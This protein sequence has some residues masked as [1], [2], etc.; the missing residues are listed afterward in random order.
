[1]KF[2]RLLLLLAIVL[3]PA[4]AQSS[5][6]S[7][8]TAAYN[9]PSHSSSAKI[10]GSG[11]HI[12][13]SGYSNP[14]IFTGTSNAAASSSVSYRESG[15]ASASSA[16]LQVPNSIQQSTSPSASSL[17][18]TLSSNGIS[19]VPVSS[20][21]GLEHHGGSFA[22]ISDDS[23]H[24][25]TGVSSDSFAEKS[26]SAAVSSSADLSK[27]VTT[28]IVYSTVDGTLTDAT[29]SWRTITLSTEVCSHDSCTR[30]I[31]TITNYVSDIGSHSSSQISSTESTSSL[32]RSSIITGA[33][34]SP[35]KHN[36]STS[37]SSS[38]V[39]SEDSKNNTPTSLLPSSYVSSLEV[40]S[41]GIPGSKSE[42]S[43]I[44]GTTQNFRDT[45][46]SNSFS[47]TAFSSSA[48]LSALSEASSKISSTITGSS[49]S[50]DISLFN[51]TISAS[52]NSLLSTWSITLA[53]STS[54]ASVRGGSS[55]PS[56][57]TLFDHVN[58]STTAGPLSSSAS[59][60]GNTS[61]SSKT[62]VP[63]NS[64]LISIAPKS[65]LSSTSDYIQALSTSIT[66]NLGNT[67][68]SNGPRDIYSTI[69]ATS[70]SFAESWQTI[71]LSTEVCSHD[72][73]TKSF[74]TTTAKRNATSTIPSNSFETS[75]VSHSV[76][77][78]SQTSTSALTEYPSTISSLPSNDSST[79]SPSP[80]PTKNLSLSFETN[81]STSLSPSSI[82][83]NITRIVSHISTVTTTIDGTSTVYTTWCPLTLTS[84]ASSEP[85]ANPPAS[86]ENSISLTDEEYFS[87]TS[88]NVQSPA[89][90]SKHG[91]SSSSVSTTTGVLNSSSSMPVDATSATPI[92]S[93]VYS[94]ETTRL[95][96]RITTVTTTIN[97]T[98]TAYTTWCPL[99]ESDATSR[100]SL[101]QSI[102]T[103]GPSQTVNSVYAS[104]HAAD[105]SVIGNTPQQKSESTNTFS[106]IND[107]TTALTESWQITTL[108]TEVCSHT[109]CIR[110]IL[111]TTKN[112]GSAISA[113]SSSSAATISEASV[114][115]AGA[116]TSSSQKAIHQPSSSSTILNSLTPSIITSSRF[117]STSSI[118]TETSSTHSAGSS[119]KTTSKVTSQTEA[120]PHSL[121][122]TL[123]TA[124][125]DASEY[126]STSQQST[127]KT[128]S[129]ITG[130]AHKAGTVSSASQ[131]RLKLSSTISTVVTT[132]NGTSTVYTTW[133]P[134][135]SDSEAPSPSITGTSSSPIEISSH[136]GDIP[137]VS[138]V[139]YTTNSRPVSIP[140]SIVSTVVT[141]INGTSTVY[142][143]WCP[144]TSESATT[145]LSITSARSNS[146][147]IS[148]HTKGT[149]TIAS[150][151]GST[152]IS[153][154]VF[155][156]SSIVS[157]IVTTINGTS[158]V[159]TTWCPLTSETIASSF[160]K[161]GS[162]S[163][164]VSPGLST[165]SSHMGS[166]SKTLPS[167]SSTITS[168]NVPERTG[169]IST[170]VTLING[171]STSYTTWCPLA[172]T[173]KV[174]SPSLESE[175][176]TATISNSGNVE[177]FSSFTPQAEV[178]TSIVH[179]WETKTVSTE[180]CSNR[181][182]SKVLITTS[183]PITITELTTTYYTAGSS[184][185]ETI[186]PSSA[187]ENSKSGGTESSSSTSFSKA[188][189]QSTSSRIQSGS[190]SPPD[191]SSQPH[192]SFTT[193]TVVSTSTTPLKTHEKRTMST[194]ITT[195]SGITTS[196]TTWCPLSD[197]SSLH[198]VST[199][200]SSRTT[201]TVITTHTTYSPDKTVS[202]IPSKTTK[203]SVIAE[204]GQSVTL[205]EVGSTSP[206][207]VAGSSHTTSLTDTLSSISSS[208]TFTSIISSWKTV[209]ISTEVCVDNACSQ[210]ALVTTT[211]HAITLY[212][213]IV[214]AN[215]WG[216]SS[217]QYAKNS[218][219]YTSLATSPS[220]SLNVSS[221]TVGTTRTTANVSTIKSTVN[222]T[223]TTYTTWCPFSSINKTSAE[224]S[225]SLFTYSLTSTTTSVI[226][227]SCRAGNSNNSKTVPSTKTPAPSVKGSTG[228]SLT[229]SSSS[230]PIDASSTTAETAF[231]SEVTRTISSLGTTI[232]SV[233]SCS[234][235]NC[236]TSRS[237][238]T[239]AAL[240][241][242]PIEDYP[243][244]TKNASINKV[245]SPSDT[246]SAAGHDTSSTT[247][248]QVF[249]AGVNKVVQSKALAIFGILVFLI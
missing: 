66:E 171:T 224:V 72:V 77:S 70:F 12:S 51:S 212:S 126:I 17:E 192:N 117:F 43:N 248:L 202:S 28:P 84:F 121:V 37:L 19:N 238:T 120:N 88:L 220:A 226:C 87:G 86:T 145:S 69:N 241:T 71:T 26:L 146:I 191:T 65:Q 54:G 25:S 58:I 235:E 122:S 118:T 97:G 103:F 110:S 2:P 213:T 186:S 39:S 243:S 131:T 1:M 172:S 222:G 74:V 149:S 165:I 227:P 200:N 82:Y 140:S 193:S 6:F 249:S 206:A 219:S 130:S 116:A 135:T 160:V 34:T 13:E 182:C 231:G 138:S 228:N 63:V 234:E 223:I 136:T 194:I 45:L 11:A 75:E 167:V 218:S 217:S 49:S 89:L 4:I 166:T 181:E 115:S 162:T 177:S 21:L 42:H 92:P 225:G 67:A 242:S 148:S 233:Q 176:S 124:S 154:P 95:L 107:I 55:Y 128:L 102:S 230:T 3:D 161:S 94:P 197:E 216:N 32:Y 78:T 15:R 44:S 187:I 143:T 90:S 184:D 48:T 7:N 73:C 189:Q 38:S 179:S 18:E 169:I 137:S 141:T 152:S 96:S 201:E 109:S 47:S 10:E 114:E 221:L 53:S 159:Y 57:G 100:S 156:P 239:S 245:A 111:T 22:S 60:I 174:H 209:T 240:T 56:T 144:L 127:E 214:S 33:Q 40:E 246:S 61:L 210:S 232:I 237:S 247:S 27:N 211:P 215:G 59:D 99:T 199:P 204:T 50:S 139:S 155:N 23:S 20:S 14:F 168:K 244:S 123:S 113:I 41:S 133:C 150:S 79:S 195:I 151:I 105:S 108:T 175:S 36:S 147:E 183:N 163:P 104:S 178:V 185:L 157:T 91:Y 164:S 236:P 112:K 68:S 93:S 173:S 5:Y 205:S 35:K 30:S 188:R 80:S 207:S 76:S 119:T 158:T 8:T 98:S 46:S 81:F 52:S 132:I 208:A 203:P 106:T 62:P 125:S 85:S 64:S 31:A 142:T 134:L 129:Y 83:F 196:Y 153:Q 190:F 180:V 101:R 24:T 198:S 9:S 170:I 16:P 29:E 229:V